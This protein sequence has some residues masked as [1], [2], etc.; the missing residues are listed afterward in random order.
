MHSPYT[1]ARDIL[2]T[3]I[4]KLTAHL[5]WCSFNSPTFCLGNKQTEQNSQIYTQHWLP[6]VNSSDTPQTVF[7][8][9]D[10]LWIQ[11]VC[12]LWSLQ[13]VRKTLGL[14]VMCGFSVLLSGKCIAIIRE[15][16]MPKLLCHKRFVGRRFDV[17]IGP[18]RAPCGR[19]IS[20]PRKWQTHQVRK[21]F[22][23]GGSVA[24]LNNHYLGLWGYVDFPSPA[25]W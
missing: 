4:N 11:G 6:F 9:M 19:W 7:I 25:C 20:P 8:S 5:K 15:R 22:L 23:S 12:E 2:G 16:C 3:A 18:Q 14:F 10:I 13:F 24:I 1:T 17:S 21:R